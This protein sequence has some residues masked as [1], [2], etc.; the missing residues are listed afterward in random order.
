MSTAELEN[1]KTVLTPEQS[2]EAE[3]Y[4]NEANV[5]FKSEPF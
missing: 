5:F 2:A 4:K 1:G 3:K